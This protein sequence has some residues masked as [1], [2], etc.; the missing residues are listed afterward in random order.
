MSEETST[1]QGRRQARQKTKPKN[2]KPK[3]GLWKKILLSI[4]TLG[5]IAIIAGGITAFVMISGAPPLD[6]EKLTLSQAAQMYDQNDELVSQLDSEE[7]RV[8]VSIQDVPQVVEDA[9]ISVEDIRFREHFG[10]DIRRLFGAVA[11]NITEGFGAEGASTITQQLVKNLFLNHEKAITRKVQE[12]YLAVKLE[13]QYSKDQILEMYLNQIYLGSGVYGIE[14]ASQTYFNK[15]VEDLSLADAALLAGIPRRPSFYDPTKN[16]EAAESRRNL[17]LDLMERHGKITSEEAA[18]AKAVP[19]EDQIELTERESYPYEA[20]YDQVLAELEQLEGIAVSDLYNAGLKVYTTLDVEAQ[21]HVEKVL[22][23]DEFISNYPDNEDFQAGVTLL[24]TRTGQI[25]AIGSG[26][27]DTNIKRGFNFAT[28]IRKQPGS[29]IKP[30]LDYGPAIEYL[31]WSTGRIIV[32]E[33]HNY[34]VGVPIR[35]FDRSYNG[36]ISMRTA[37]ARSRNVTAIKAL[38]EV[39]VDRAEAF[40]EGLGIPIEYPDGQMP[41]AFG[42]GGFTNG[43]STLHLAGAY[44]AFGNNGTYTKP[45]T[46]RKIVFPDGRE[47]NMEPESTQAM[48]DYTAYMITDMLK[49]AVTNGTGT[50]ANISGL[51]MAGKTGTTNFPEDVRTSLGIP[52]GEVPDVWFAGYTTNYTAAVWTG[53][54]ENGPNNYL[55]SG[56]DRQLAQQI[57]KEIVGKVSEGKETPDFTRPNS[58]VE[59]GVERSTGLLPSAYTPRSEII[60]E[61]FVRGNEPTRVSE[62]FINLA[63][64][65]NFMGSYNEAANQIL[66]SWN[67]PQESADNVTFELQVSV[68]GGSAQS[69]DRTKDM[70]F[71]FGSPERGRSYVFT[72]IAI[73]DET[74]NLRSDPATVQVVAGEVME[75]EETLPDPL[76]EV[77]EPEQELEPEQ[78]PVEDGN[79]PTDGEGTLPEDDDEGSEQPTPDT[80]TDEEETSEEDN[81]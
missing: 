64:P 12:Q 36:A 81:A 4:V 72:V 48:S 61:L 44:A 76:E 17:V 32:D 50:T 67:Y 37:L 33:P 34:S 39:G 79:N 23:T 8:N 73:S 21:E 77:D 69:L 18:A 65:S 71:V 70:Q 55:R 54:N 45:Y 51:P 26:L 15:S 41:E 74:A 7:R 30:I 3:K 22:Q 14:L 63:S 80:G 20:F 40:A 47:I 27:Q 29:T 66:L 56:Q 59:V 31:Q 57:F 24:D 16:P 11:A 42:L 46:V 49:T 78:P 68:D 9:F 52:E 1:R 43:I 10:I 19:L 28:D 60:Y 62:E 5:I 75:E 6:A 2:K 13:Q 53:F 58:V 38:Q 35:N 25:K